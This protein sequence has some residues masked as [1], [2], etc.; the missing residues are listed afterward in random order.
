VVSGVG[1]TFF[2]TGAFMLTGSPTFTP[3]ALPASQNQTLTQDTLPPAGGSPISLVSQ[4]ACPSSTVCVATGTAGSNQAILSGAL[5]GVGHDSWTAATAAGS[6]TGLT[7]LTCPVATSCLIAGTSTSAGQPDG[8]LLTGSPGPAATWPLISL[9]AAET[10]LP[11][12]YGIGC[13]PVANAT[14][15]AV[16]AGTQSAAFT[17]TTTGP[18][19]QWTDHTSDV[20][21][22]LSGN[23]VTGVPIELATAGSPGIINTASAN[24]GYW[25]AIAAGGSTNATAIGPIYPFTSGYTVFAAD[26]PSEQ[27]TAAGTVLA[28][29]TPG[30]TGP[31][32]VTVPLGVLALQ[33]VGVLAVPSS[34]T[35]Y[36]QST[37]SS[38]CSTH[39]YVLQTPG[40]DGLSRTEVPFGTYNLTM[41]S[42]IHTTTAVTVTVNPGSDIVGGTTTPLPTVVT[43]TGP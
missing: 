24:N 11:Y 37:A 29:G 7:S 33:V 28:S 18:A 14:C 27:P 39:R 35:V 3:P 22:T 42:G 8:V 2:T 26:C 41:T 23:V 6:V 5:A 9:P 21:L 20:G 36:L 30:L 32:A 31:P 38:P 16:G 19:G 43:V 12:F 10:G 13:T 4:L 40:A 1:T 17:S 34:D 15:T 25:N